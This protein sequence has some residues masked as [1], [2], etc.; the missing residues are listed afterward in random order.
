VPG[1]APPLLVLLDVILGRVPNVVLAILAE[2]TSS[3]G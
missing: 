3:D 2:D 1:A